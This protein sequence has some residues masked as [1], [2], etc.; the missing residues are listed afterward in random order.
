M[1]GMTLAIAMS[2]LLVIEDRCRTLFGSGL[3]PDVA[4]PFVLL[5]GLHCERPARLTL[6]TVLACCRA[7]LAREPVGRDLLVMLLAT[8]AL[9]HARRVVF[10]KSFVNLLVLAGLTALWFVCGRTVFEGLIDQRPVEVL[11]LSSASALSALLAPLVVRFVVW[12]RALG[13]LVENWT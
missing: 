11:R 6:V 3:V 8:E 2:V 12:S 9:A 1:R 10:V 13:D 5:F 7:L 4:L